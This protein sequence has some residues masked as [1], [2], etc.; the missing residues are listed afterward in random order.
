MT[1]V[2]TLLFLFLATELYGA[3]K[4]SGRFA[5]KNQEVLDFLSR[6]QPQIELGE[7]GDFKLKVEH[8]CNGREHYQ[9][10]KL[11][12]IHTYGKKA[13]ELQVFNKKKILSTRFKNYYGLTKVREIKIEEDVLTWKIREENG[14]RSIQRIGLYPNGQVEFY[15]GRSHTRYSNNLLKKI[16]CFDF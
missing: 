2:F 5:T 7:C 6:V 12:V 14:V 16:S 13:Q 1:K 9:Y 3:C 8:V 15:E 4:P 10:T 11:S